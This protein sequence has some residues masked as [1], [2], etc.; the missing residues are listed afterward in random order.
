M[1]TADGKYAVCGIFSVI[2]ALHFHDI[3][4]TMKHM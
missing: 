4:D 3:H 2:Y 1:F